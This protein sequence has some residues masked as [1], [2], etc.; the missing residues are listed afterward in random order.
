MTVTRQFSLVLSLVMLLVSVG[1]SQEF[2]FEK[3]KSKVEN[4]T[5]ILDIQVEIS[6]GAQTNTAEQEL[7][8]TLVS[9][10]GLVIFDG[11]MLDFS[12]PFSVVSG[13]MFKA[14]PTKIVA[15][16]LSGEEYDAE[17]I[18]VDSYTRL[19]FVRLDG[20]ALKGRQ[21]VKFVTDYSFKT[22][23][24]LTMLGL[25]PKHVTPRLGAAMGMI[26][27]VLTEPEPF[28]V[29]SG[30]RQHRSGQVIYSQE[31]EPLGVLGLL[32]NFS[33]NGDNNGSPFD[34]FGDQVAPVVGVIIGETINRLIADPPVV[35]NSTRAW[36]GITLQALT[37]DI[38]EFLNIDAPGGIIVNNVVK[39]SPASQAGL[40]IGDVIIEVNGQQLQV[41][42]E[43]RVPIFQRLISEMEPGSAVEL[44][45]IRP[46]DKAPQSFSMIAN[47]E[48]APMSASEA[49]DY[50]NEQLDLKVR[51]LVFADYLY[52]NM[53][54]ETL[55]GVVVTEL[56][57][58]G[59]AM[60]GGLTFGDIIQQ[61]NGQTVES[62]DEVEAILEKMVE[63]K[64]SEVIFFVFRDSKTLFVNLKTG[65]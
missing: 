19:G 47:L 14:T 43:E 30:F 61:I 17:Y 39:G 11:T 21:P 7:M 65:F 29:T 52:Y 51:D 22:G 31:L 33:D 46:A 15:K 53:D 50:E 2:D 4:Y 44:A 45:V 27:A 54:E 40:E 9:E 23:Q 8:G 16:S 37:S 60:I 10:D 13:S 63:D 58:S 32:N 38:A 18:G 48:A 59:P 12:H 55:W 57:N 26:T 28:P 49:P 41:D 64:P 56:E 42:S 20:D 1:S 24:W 6:M 35:G 36:L 3:L 25:L 34:G 5:V 62:V